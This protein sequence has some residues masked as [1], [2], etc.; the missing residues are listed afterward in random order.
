MPDFI[1]SVKGFLRS[2]AKLKLDAEQKGDTRAEGAYSDRMEW[3][4]AVIGEIE[5]YRRITKPIPAAYGDLSDL[6]PE[7]VKEL[8][9][10]KVDDLEQ[11]LFTIIKTG[12]DEVDLDAILIE[13]FR[14]FQVVQ[15]RKFLQNKL[16][17]MAQKEIVFSVAGRKGV[18]TAQK[19]SDSWG[20]PPP[21]PVTFGAGAPT[22]SGFADDLDE[23][24]PF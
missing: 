13:L 8:T 6:P 7:L 12:G 5:H 24:I 16:W 18:Y 3:L 22:K 4:E 11:Q 2:T 17:R 21:A 15:T 19:P 20:S 9:G 23:D 10:T 14:R 1:D